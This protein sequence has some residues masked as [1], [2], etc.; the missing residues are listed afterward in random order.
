MKTLKDKVMSAWNSG[1]ELDEV[2]AL[3]GPE[4]EPIWSGLEAK[5]GAGSIPV[6]DLYGY[7]SK[8]PTDPAYRQ[9]KGL[10]GPGKQLRDIIRLSGNEETV[11]ENIDMPHDAEI[12]PEE[13]FSMIQQGRWDLKRFTTWLSNQSVDSFAN[14]DWADE[15]FSDPEYKDPRDN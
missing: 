12:T 5:Y 14:D 13:A 11:D 15:V 4:V 10:D 3:Y 6:P 8:E 7:K 1:M 9:W 2:I